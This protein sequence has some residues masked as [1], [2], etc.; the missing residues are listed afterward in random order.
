M[1]K[2]LQVTPISKF[3]FI[4]MWLHIFRM[5]IGMPKYYDHWIA[6]FLESSKLEGFVG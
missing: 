5:F 4:N 2:A 3:T 1:N 6:Y